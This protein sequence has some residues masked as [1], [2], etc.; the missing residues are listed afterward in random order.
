MDRTVSAH[1]EMARI[2]KDIVQAKSKDKL[3]GNVREVIINDGAKKIL[4][5]AEV[6]I[7]DSGRFKSYRAKVLRVLNDVVRKLQ[8]EITSH[9]T[10]EYES[11]MESVVEVRREDG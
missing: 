9:Y 5:F 11:N 10:V 7:G 6:T 1:D 8:N 3:I 4:D 2:K